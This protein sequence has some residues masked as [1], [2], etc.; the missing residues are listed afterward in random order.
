MESALT[1]KRKADEINNGQD[2]NYGSQAEQNHQ[3]WTPTVC[4]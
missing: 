1:H 3:T 4:A 2:V